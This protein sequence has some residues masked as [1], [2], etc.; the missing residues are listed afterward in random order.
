MNFS[1]ISGNFCTSRKLHKKF[2]TLLE[3]QCYAVRYEPQH[4]HHTSRLRHIVLFY[5]LLHSIC[6][7]LYASRLARI[8]HA[9]RGLG[10][11]GR[12]CKYSV[13]FQSMDSDGL[14]HPNAMVCRQPLRPAPRKVWSRAA[15][16]TLDSAGRQK[17]IL[18]LKKIQQ[19][20]IKLLLK[21]ATFSRSCER[22]PRF[23]DCVCKTLSLGKTVCKVTDA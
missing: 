2:P 22:R 1:V 23:L 9:L 3:V 13:P 19:K 5:A 14:V 8:L 7:P 12:H 15:T 20:T 17:K 6:S 16:G 18:F 21:N 11:E 4:D 10:S